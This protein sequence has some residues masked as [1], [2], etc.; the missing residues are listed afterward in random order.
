MLIV[1]VAT[2]RRWV[3]LVPMTVETATPDDAVARVRGELAARPEPDQGGTWHSEGR[4]TLRYQMT[5]VRRT[6]DESAVP[7][8]K[9]GQG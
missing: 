8:Y 3:I 2:M 6:G 9:R 5:S 4:A 7:Q 1:K